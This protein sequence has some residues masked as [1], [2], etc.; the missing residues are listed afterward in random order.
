[1]TLH[2]YLKTESRVSESLLPLFSSSSSL[3][4]VSHFSTNGI[5]NSIANANARSQSCFA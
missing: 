2:T 4:N 5:P 3:F 1:M